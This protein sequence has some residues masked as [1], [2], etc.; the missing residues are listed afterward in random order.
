MKRC[1]K[2]L[3]LGS[4][5]EYGVRCE[6]TAKEFFFTICHEH[7]FSLRSFHKLIALP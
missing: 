6:S 1:Q 5:L 2:G 7:V 4:D 3:N